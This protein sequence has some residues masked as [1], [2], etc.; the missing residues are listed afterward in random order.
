[1][2]DRIT[3][4]R[5]VP[6]TTAKVPLEHG[7]V[8]LI[9]WNTDVL[10][11]FG[12]DNSPTVEFVGMGDAEFRIRFFYAPPDGR[13]DVLISEVRFPFTVD[14]HLGDGEFASSSFD[15]GLFNRQTKVL[16][17]SVKEMNVLHTLHWGDQS[18]YEDNLEPTD[19]DGD[20]DGGSSSTALN[21]SE[22]AGT[23]LGAFLRNLSGM[24]G[25]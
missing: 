22:V 3:P 11:L 17:N 10:A 16:H 5:A 21:I 15:A 20:D 2:E 12:Q 9:A 6:I 7:H 8:E 14:L 19:G 13:P 18:D 24:S 4:P 25:N 23:F 1:M